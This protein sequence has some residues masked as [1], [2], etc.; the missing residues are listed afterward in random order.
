MTVTEFEA[1]NIQELKHDIRF[2]S[3]GKL[4][5]KYPTLSFKFIEVAKQ[6]NGR[7]ARCYRNQEKIRMIERAV[8][9]VTHQPWHNSI[10]F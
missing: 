9:C 3:R 6:L 1:I 2:L 5:D 10:S 4:M 7:L 8:N